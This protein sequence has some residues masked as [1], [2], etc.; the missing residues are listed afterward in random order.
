MTELASLPAC[1]ADELGSSRAGGQAG[2]QAGSQR[3]S[4]GTTLK[5][6]LVK[7]EWQSEGRQGP[8]QGDI[9]GVE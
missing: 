2:R 4:R 1:S 3:A 5:H 6:R 8:S 9:G 7:S